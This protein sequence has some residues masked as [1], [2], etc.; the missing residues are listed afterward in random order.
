MLPKMLQLRL[1]YLALLSFCFSPFVLAEDKPTIDVLAVYT[2]GA[3]AE[4]AGDPTTRI[5][6]LFAVSNQIYKD[7]GINLQI[8]L[9]K[10][11]AVNYTDDNA[12]ET[13]LN[14]ITKNTNSAFA[15]IS[16]L[17]E[18]YKA[19]MVILYR[20]YK[21]VHGSCGLAWIG[22]MGSN[23]DFSN[24]QYK[25]YMF[26]H[27]AITVCGDYV[28]AHELGHNMGLNH[29]RKQDTT[30]GTFGYALGYGVDGLFTDIMAY[31]SSFNVDYW[32]GK[33]YKFSSPLLT[34]RGVPC[35]ISRTD[36]V[37]GAD[38][39]YTLN[40]TAPQIAKFYAAPTTT[41]GT[42]S[43]LEILNQKVTSTKAAYDQAV[44]A[45]A[46]NKAAI[47]NKTAAQTAA[48]AALT[49]ATAAVTAA[50]TK[51]E[52]TLKTYKTAST[53]AAAI[54]PKVSA[55]LTKYKSSTTNQAKANN[56]KEYN[57]QNANYAAAVKKAADALAVSETA[58]IATEQATTALK[59]AT[60]ALSTAKQALTTEQGLTAGLT[61]AVTTT[62][63]ANAAA[64]AAYNA[65]VQKAAATK[66]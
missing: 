21:D 50:K 55:A 8:R 42:L 5:N 40:I 11:V 19:D 24:S 26:A 44:T 30:G 6:Q 39:V 27:I 38:A 49:K 33:E 2:Q 14:D 47:T 12:A 51:Y 25:S 3:A 63:A 15:N 29:S 52:T 64:V 18:Q 20:P 66:K 17:R 34:C 16:A 45:L 58:R 4:Y 1:R 54:A 53:A 59:T 36:T 57:T 13:A 43:E 22:G 56:L 61:T 46:N 10:A 41:A 65:A 23:G 28:T 35:G 31:T 7:S 48:Q 60:T 62:K 9:A 32:A 37:N